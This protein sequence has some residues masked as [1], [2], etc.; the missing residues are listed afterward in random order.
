MAELT[1]FQKLV[2]IGLEPSEARKIEDYSKGSMAILYMKWHEKPWDRSGHLA[3]LPEELQHAIVRW[4]F[5]SATCSL[6]LESRYDLL[7]QSWVF[8]EHLKTLIAI[9]PKIGIIANMEPE[10]VALFTGLPMDYAFK[11]QEYASYY[12]ANEVLEKEYSSRSVSRM[13]PGGEEE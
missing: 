2:I 6:E 9:A 13:D 7:P 11:V 3:D 4:V 8:G 10:H 5:V 1:L 12:L